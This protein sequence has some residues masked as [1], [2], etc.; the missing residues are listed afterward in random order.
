VHTLA[1]EGLVHHLDLTLELPSP[2]LPDDAYGLVSEVLVG[3]LG[4]GLPTSW[5]PA[6]AVLKGTGRMGLTE[7]DRAALGPAA[8]RFP[9]FG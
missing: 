2:W 4:A 7:A 6:E 3:L 9:L 8:D 1:V 5:S